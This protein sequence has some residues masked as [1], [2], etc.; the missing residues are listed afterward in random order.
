MAICLQEDETGNIWIGTNDNNFVGKGIEIVNPSQQSI[1]TIT[2]ENGL[3]TNDIRGL[4]YN[5]QQMWI[6]TGNGLNII[7]NKI[8]HR[9]N[10]DVTALAED[11]RGK[12]WIVTIQS[13]V[14]IFDTATETMHCFTTKQGLS[15]SEME[16]INT[17]GTIF[18]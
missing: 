9:S 8:K 5:Q 13:G 18:Y 10:E 17:A 12:I 16:D 6:A 14:K 11:T 3:N 2:A 1:K 15:S 4:F 7:D